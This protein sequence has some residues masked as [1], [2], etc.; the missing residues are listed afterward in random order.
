MYYVIGKSLQLDSPLRTSSRLSK[1]FQE[2]LH[3]KDALPYFIQYMESKD[4]DHL[5]RFWLDAESF[6]AATWTRIRTQSMQ[7]LSRSSV[8][9]SSETDYQ[10]HSEDTSV[11]GENSAI[12]PNERH[13]SVSPTTSDGAT[14]SISGTTE[15]SANRA[16]GADANVPGANNGHPNSASTSRVGGNSDSANSPTCAKSANTNASLKVSAEQIVSDR[17]EEG[18]SQSS[19]SSS[20]DIQSQ[21]SQDRTRS[22]HFPSHD[23]ANCETVGTVCRGELTATGHVPASTISPSQL[24]HSAKLNSDASNHKSTNQSEVEE[25][26]S[27]LMN[28]ASNQTVKARSGSQEEK[29][30]KSKHLTVLLSVKPVLTYSCLS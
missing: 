30:K 9:R 27:Q 25:R 3:D 28:V 24:T 15:G 16:A 22:K 7:S 6:Q 19:S 20:A 18:V 26:L 2:I 14:L 11:K 1:T 29:Y 17:L 5:I 23:N 21:T 4:A 13:E 10:K 8:G 12:S